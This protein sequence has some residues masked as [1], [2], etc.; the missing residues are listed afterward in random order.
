[1]CINTLYAFKENVLI[2]EEFKNDI[3]TLFDFL[4]NL[5]ICLVILLSIPELHES[6]PSFLDNY[7]IKHILKSFIFG[8]FVSLYVLNVLW[9]FTSLEVKPNHK[10]HKLSFCASVFMTVIFTICI[11]GFAVINV[12]S[13][14]ITP[15]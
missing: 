15:Y 11:I 8:V 1:M 9:L 13:L 14:L 4:R 3:K 2:T 7:Y 6:G 12:W 5:G 10:Y